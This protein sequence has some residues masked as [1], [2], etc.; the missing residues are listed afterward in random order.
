MFLIKI[1]QLTTIFI[2]ATILLFDIIKVKSNDVAYQQPST[3]LSPAKESYYDGPNEHEANLL[4]CLK[5]LGEIKKKSGEATKKPNYIK[6]EY[7]SEEID[8]Y[9]RDFPP[10]YEPAFQYEKLKISDVIYPLKY[11]KKNYYPERKNEHSTKTSYPKPE[12]TYKEEEKPEN[13][14]E[15]KINYN[16]ETIEKK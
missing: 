7:I 8:S 14:Y 16:F 3:Y 13:N 1:E 6:K 11:K 9:E 12:T 10:N 4:K 2:C 15:S 5:E